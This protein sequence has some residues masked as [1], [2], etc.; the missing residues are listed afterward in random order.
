MVEGV[1]NTNLIDRFKCAPNKGSVCDRKPVT[2]P[3]I[4]KTELKQD[5]LDLSSKRKLNITKENIGWGIALGL[6]GVGLF[7][8]IKGLRRPKISTVKLK[9]LAEHIEFTKAKTLEEAMEFG[10]KHLGIKDYKGFENADIDA[11]NWVNEGLVNV[12]NYKKGKL[13][14]PDI[15]EYEELNDK[16][17]ACVLTEGKKFLNKLKINKKLF[18]NL[19]EKI[20]ER[21]KNSPFSDIQMFSG[22]SAGTLKKNLEKFK[23]KEKLDFNEK[24]QLYEDLEKLEHESLRSPAF[25][26]KEIINNPQAREKLI[27]Q[28]ILTG[29]NHT[30]IEWAKGISP[31]DTEKLNS[32]DYRA[33]NVVKKI[34]LSKS[35]YRFE[36]ETAS[37]FRTIFHEVGH[38]QYKPMKGTGQ[39]EVTESL[40]KYWNG[41]KKAL[42][43]AL[44]V[45]RYAGTSPSEFLA[46]V[47]AEKVSGHKLSDEV[48]ELEKKIINSTK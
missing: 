7:H 41:D 27:Q 26:I 3:E 2:R 6:I 19:D 18:S 25:R 30:L 13:M 40:E 23:N 24:V 8:T 12:S 22:E 5:T 38:L 35:G 34:L 14:F 44:T 16:T 48:I 28:G 47:F 1:N 10:K 43:T 37:P 46:E 15:I 29:E 32:C 39:M 20:A 36:H 17:M 11:I 42:S 4:P 33:L 9:Q 21:I 45:S 31:I